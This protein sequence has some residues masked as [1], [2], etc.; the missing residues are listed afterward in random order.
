[1]SIQLIQK[2]K[3]WDIGAFGELYDLSYERVYRFIFYRVLDTSQTED[4][5]SDIYM[6]AMRSIVKFRWDSEWEF[7]AWILQVSY[8]TLIDSTRKVSYTDSLDDITWEPWYT[9]DVDADIDTHDTLT[10]VLGYMDTLTSRDKDIVMMRIWDDLSYAQ[11]SDI[12]W[13][14]VANSKQIVS[15]TLQKIAANVQSFCLL[16]LFLSHVITR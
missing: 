2:A 6:K 14:S 3:S 5:I 7:F 8:T 13:V 10:R 16:S 1:M 9:P 12:T 4:L 15:R 11:I